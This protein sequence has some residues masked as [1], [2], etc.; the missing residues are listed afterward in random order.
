M[1]GDEWPQQA[2]IWRLRQIAMYFRTKSFLEY[3]LLIATAR[4]SIDRPWNLGASVVSAASCRDCIP[5]PVPAR[6]EK[7]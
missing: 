1:A 2:F 3:G 7:T 5:S 6:I 4:R